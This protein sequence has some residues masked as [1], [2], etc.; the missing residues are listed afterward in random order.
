MNFRRSR[1][2]TTTQVN[3]SQPKKWR[4]FIWSIVALIVGVAG[5]I[6]LTG[7]LA[8]KS[9]T[10][11]N[12]SDAP[13]FFRFG[14]DLTPDELSSEGDSR[15]N[16]LAVGLDKAA[17]L[18]DSLQIMSIDPINNKLA[19]LSVPRDLFVK[20]KDGVKTKINEVYGRNK[21]I[22]TKKTPSCDPAHDY[23][24][25]ALK[26]VIE[27]NF[28]LNL[29][30]FASIDFD[31]LK[32]IVDALGG[33][34]VTVTQALYDPD[35]PCDNNPN[36]ACGY[37]QPSGKH[38]M[39]GTQV[40]KYSRCRKGTCGNDFGRAERQQQVLG[41]IKDKVISLGTI[42]NPKRLTDL[43]SAA[44]SHLRTDV[45][46]TDG[47]KMLG[48]IEKVNL[49]QIDK[50]VLDSSTDSPLKSATNNIGQYI[51]IPKKGADDFSEVKEFVQ[52]VFPEPYII[53][54]AATVA[55]VDASGKA[56]TGTAVKTKLTLLGYKVLS[57]TTAPASQVQSTI[58]EN[59]DKP[60]T[61]SLLKKRFYAT[62]SKTK[63]TAADVT[64][65]I[66]SKYLTK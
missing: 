19:M 51:L 14:G 46:L 61:V 18:T 7:L 44:G 39:N 65:T 45:Q 31:G 62:F 3:P 13:S 50:N 60:F 11:K 49:G 55:L 58:T 59:K 1:R 40:L 30:Y 38:H 36:A 6:S 29:H 10:A 12:S 56:G 4:Y 16:I 35:Y 21:K 34:D 26:D 24:A 9:I 20:G 54:E 28:G 57:V 8:F 41:L 25:E 42:S 53:R 64:V 66:G 15:I 17:G 37:T 2:Q 43:M 33:L 5:W 27:T 48:L 22:C 63:S 52:S 32:K 23:G 47:I